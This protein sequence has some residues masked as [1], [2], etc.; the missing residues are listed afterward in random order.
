MNKLEVLQNCTV[1]GMV[2]KMPNI[3]IDRDVFLEVKKAIIKIGG[4]WKGGKVFGFVFLSDP[5]RLLNKIS[6]GENINLKKEFQ[7]FETQEREVNQ[8]IELAELKH[9]D[10][11]LEPSCGQGA[12]VKAINKLGMTCDAYE[13][14]ETNR[15]VMSN[16][17]T[18]N[19]NLLGFDFL[20]SN[21][22]K[23]DKIIANPPFSKNQDI[24]HVRKMIEKLKD[25]GRITA[26]M[27]THWIYSKNKK[28][29][30]F[31]EFLKIFD[32]NIIDIEKGSF[33]KS[34]TNVATV[35]LI[36]NR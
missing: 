17:P 9:G 26:I 23:Y 4:K 10:E 15:V 3:Q 21:N 31:R 11:I 28:E 20:D 35:I 14:M 30:A 22:K 5:T 33:K 7:F 13:L 29:T 8:L 19:F 1:E 6:S 34:G 27:S 25:G 24:D 18:L 2:I 32:Y 16:N 36:L 12:I